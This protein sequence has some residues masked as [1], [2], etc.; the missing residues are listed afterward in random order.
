MISVYAP[1]LKAPPGVRHNFYTDLQDTLDKG[2]ES[3]VL[4]LLGDFNARVGNGT[5]RGPVEPDEPVDPREPVEP[6]ETMEPR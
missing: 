3:D 5:S 4:L 2:K 6:D 1:T